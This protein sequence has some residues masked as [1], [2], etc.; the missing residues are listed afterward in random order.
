MNCLHKSYMYNKPETCP[1]CNKWWCGVGCKYCK[2]GLKHIC[3][4]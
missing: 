1:D 3:R 2:D 4:K